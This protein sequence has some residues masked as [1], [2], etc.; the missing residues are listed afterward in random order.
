MV[1]RA[2]EE[3]DPASAYRQLEHDP[4]VA[5]RVV[6]GAFFADPESLRVGTFPVF[7]R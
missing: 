3:P 6:R 2:A 7:G 1:Q 5:I 4:G